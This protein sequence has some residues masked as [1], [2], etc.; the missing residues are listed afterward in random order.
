MVVIENV[1]L[2]VA[3][4]KGLESITIA[5]L[6]TPIIAAKV[7]LSFFSISKFWSNSSKV[8]ISLVS[9]SFLSARTI[10]EISLQ[11]LLT[12]WLALSQSNITLFNKEKV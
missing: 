12:Y 3:S 2:S 8:N 9:F 5:T 1:F 11:P 6:E 7:I 4:S 10:L